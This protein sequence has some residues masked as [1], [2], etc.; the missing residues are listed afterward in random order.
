[1]DWRSITDPAERRKQRRLAKNRVTAARSRERKKEQWSEMQAALSALQADNTS[2]KAALDAALRENAQLK[3]Q[4]GSLNRGLA[5]AAA[6]TGQGAE[7]AALQCL[8]IMHL[9]CPESR[10]GLPAPQLGRP[11]VHS[12]RLR[13]CPECGL[14]CVCPGVPQQ[15]AQQLHAPSCDPV[16]RGGLL[17]PLRFCLVSLPCLQ[18]C[19]PI[20][21]WRVRP[22]AHQPH[23]TGWWRA[24][25]PWRLLPLMAS[26]IHPNRQSRSGGCSLEPPWKRGHQLALLLQWPWTV[27]VPA[28]LNPYGLSTCA[29][30]GSRSAAACLGAVRHHCRMLGAAGVAWAHQAAQLLPGGLFP[31][32]FC[33]GFWGLGGQVEVSLIGAPATRAVL[34]RRCWVAPSWQAYRGAQLRTSQ[35]VQQRGVWCGVL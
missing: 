23:S 16:W 30:A 26:C 7:P 3:Q 25:R 22:P 29:A 35:R 27:A 21:L 33:G 24:C 11:L 10:G 20:L 19:N 2:L 5:A 14:V 17:D 32:M 31:V 15:P 1:V 4:L 28:Q 8:V 9:V 34:D 6:T 13:A 12:A 18:H